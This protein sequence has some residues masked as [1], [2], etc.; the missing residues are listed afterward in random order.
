MGSNQ[1]FSSSG[2][3]KL[4]KHIKL[5]TTILASESYTYDSICRI[6]L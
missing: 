4:T 6:N 3:I 5:Y 2:T 1:N